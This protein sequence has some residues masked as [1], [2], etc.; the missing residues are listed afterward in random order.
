M[1][2]HNRNE[3]SDL[4]Y[5]LFPC[6]VRS[7]SDWLG[8]GGFERCCKEDHGRYVRIKHCLVLFACKVP[9]FEAPFSTSFSV[10]FAIGR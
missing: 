10:S 5:C 8:R 4:R 3:A 6:R 9:K 1:F 2:E 7:K